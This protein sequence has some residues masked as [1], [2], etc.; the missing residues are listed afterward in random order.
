MDVDT[1]IKI[2]PIIISAVALIIAWRKAP[3]EAQKNEAEAASEYADATKNYLDIAERQRLQIE[4]LMK[5]QEDMERELKEL[6]EEVKILRDWS[7]R[8]CNQVKSHNDIPV[9]MII[10]NNVLKRKVG[11]NRDD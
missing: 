9:P 1:I 7:S 10:E 4:N 11:V 3:S 5:K 6:R 2:L 8:L